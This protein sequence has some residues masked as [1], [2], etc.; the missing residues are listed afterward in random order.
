MLEAFKNHIENFFP[1]L[2]DT[3]FIIA[4]SGG[5]DSTALVELC[6]QANL[7]FSI[8]HCNFRLR[9][10]ASDGDEGFVRDYARKIEKEVFVT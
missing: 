4:C 3:H 5:L 8:A 2:L 6:H 7:K 9:G 10:K 1:E